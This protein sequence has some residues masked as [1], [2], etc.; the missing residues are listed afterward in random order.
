[1]T[2]RTT[3]EPQLVDPARRLP[4]PDEVP[5]HD[6]LGRLSDRFAVPMITIEAAAG[7]GKSTLL[8]QAIDANLDAPIG[9]DVVEVLARLHAVEPADVGLGDLGRREGYVA[10]QLRRWSKQWTSSKT[11]AIPEMER[12]QRGD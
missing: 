2:E 11:R 10:R 12:A 8:G 1:M 4:L 9:L 3:A 6:L 7:F 5:R